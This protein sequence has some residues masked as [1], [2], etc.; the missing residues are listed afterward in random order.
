MEARYLSGNRIGAWAEVF[1]G[2]NYPLTA[3]AKMAYKMRANTKG[4]TS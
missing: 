3:Y 1:V 2:P 4:G